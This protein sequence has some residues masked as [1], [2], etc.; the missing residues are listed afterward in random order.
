GII[1]GGAMRAVLDVAVVHNVLSK[2]YGST[3]TIN[4]V[5]ATIKALNDMKSPEQVAAKRGLRVEEILG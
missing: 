4:V 2:A 3:N 5:R 1:A